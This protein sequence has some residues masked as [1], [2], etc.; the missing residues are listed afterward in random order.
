MAE[1]TI[2]IVKEKLLPATISELAN[3]IEYTQHWLDRNERLSK[4]NELGL[5]HKNFISGFL[6]DKQH[7]NGDEYHLINTDGII[8][9]LNAKTKKLITIKGARGGQIYRYYKSLNNNA[10]IPKE[11]LEMINRAYDRENSDNPIHNM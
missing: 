4:Y 9:I 8:F 7:K 11:D 5:I 3:S 1:R 6:V 10:I 2:M